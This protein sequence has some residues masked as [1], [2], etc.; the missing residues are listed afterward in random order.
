MVFPVA[1]LVMRTEPYRALKNW[2]FWIVLWEKTLES[3]LDS[4]IKP[5]NPKG[6]QPWI[7]TGRTDA[8]TEA[9][10]VW[11]P[12]V[13]DS[14][15]KTLMLGKIEGKRR[16]GQP[17]MTWWNSNSTDMNLSQ[18]WETVKDRKAWHAAVHGVAKSQIQH[19]KWTTAAATLVSHGA[20]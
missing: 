2:W 11:P 3:P 6:N 12:D 9:S 7:S 13:A 18:L 8:G 17:R 1:C 5:I 4:K 14:L 15:E 10:I 20:S 19:S 16:R